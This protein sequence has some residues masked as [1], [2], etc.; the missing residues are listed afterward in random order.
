MSDISTNWR[1][2]DEPPAPVHVAISGA[3]G[4][5]AYGLV[6]RIA[7][8]ELFGSHQPIALRL[9]D[10]EGSKD[11]L[12]A[13]ELELRDCAF[14]LLDSLNLTTSAEDAFVDADWIVMLACAA[15][16]AW[17]APRL[18]LVRA[19]APLYAE[20][21]QVIN[22]VAV[23][24]V[25]VVSEPCNTNCLVALHQAP[26]VPKEHWFA[27]NRLARMRATAMI[28]E[29]ASVPV[30]QVNRVTVWGNHSEQIFV[31][32]HNAFVG[33]R[34]AY[35]V[36]SDPDWPRQVLEP[37]VARRESEV[38]RLRGATPAATAVQAILGTIRSITVPTPFGRRFGAAVHSEGAYGVPRGLV[39]GLP[40]RTED[41]RSWSIVDGLY[42]DEYANSRIQ[43]NIDDLEREAVIAGL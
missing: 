25:L 1:P 33:A 6:F 4:R 29:K 11:L 39:F 15:Q 18:D 14:P 35:Q 31:D 21:G 9:L 24:R 8:G 23:R 22:R 12:T 10:V 37:A 27:L 41:G 38:Y 3:A 26:N 7:A 43:E 42:L 36:I 19:N 13:I 16:T 2:G 17:N 32:L 28:A 5:V 20:H 40:L 34:P 30:S